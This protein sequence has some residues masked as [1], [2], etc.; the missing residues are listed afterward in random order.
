MRTTHPSLRPVFV[1]PSTLLLLGLWLAAPLA[2][3]STALQPRGYKA[4]ACGLDMNRNGVVGEPAGPDPLLEPG[5]CNV[6][7]GGP[8]HPTHPATGTPDPDGDGVD[9]DLIY[10]DTNNGS[11]IS[12]TGSALAPYQ[13]L[14]KAW[15]EAD[16]PGDGAEDIVCFRGTSN[17]IS[18]TPPTG[19]RG[20]ATTYTVPAAGSQARDWQY[21]SNP[22]M[23]VGWDRDNDG[24]YPPYDDGVQD[25]E[26]CGG[27]GGGAVLSGNTAS[28]IRA[29]HLAPDVG[30]LEIA[31]L[32][33]RDYGRL[34]GPTN[35]GFIKFSPDSEHQA[36]YLHD[37]EL[38]R[39]NGS[40]SS[41]SNIIA[42]DLFNTNLHWVAFENMLFEDNGGWF[43]RGTPH[44][45]ED[46]QSDA[47]PL[48]WQHITRI[49]LADDGGATNGFKPWG[50]ITGAEVLDSIFDMNLGAWSPLTGSGNA[51]IAFAIVQCN[52]DW[53]IRNNELIDYWGG[54]RINGSANG[55]CDNATA[56]PTTDIVIDR[57]ILRNTFTTW[58]F[59]H[60]A[61][62]ITGDDAGGQEGD[63][64]G[65]VVGTVTVSNNFLSSVAGSNQG[66][67]ESCIHA[68]PGNDAAPPPGS[69]RIVNN[70][71]SGPMRRDEG[72]GIL[73]G[74]TVDGAPQLQ[75]F[76]QQSF[77]VKNNIITNLRTNDHNVLLG[78]IPSNFQSDFNVYDSDGRYARWLG[79]NL[80][81]VG[82]LGAWR[83]VVPGDVSSTECYPLF[84]DGA[85]GNFHLRGDDGCAV[86]AG[87]A[88]PGIT[89]VDI[90]GQDRPLTGPWDAGADDHLQIFSDGF[91]S[92]DLD[93][94]SSATIP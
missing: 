23:L 8:N 35:S 59:G 13:T 78:Y 90:D 75:N 37:L 46:G 67:W 6:C 89:R 83:G 62:D 50:Y 66:Y 68:N 87:V 69:I 14:A 79:G 61:I 36:I 65:E 84:A 29:F 72:A 73:I 27:N 4:R 30:Y 71:C 58:D 56:R 24:C 41:D 33:V 5:D 3:V 28:A 51:T 81:G 22:A 48:R 77:V 52:Q 45:G 2:A 44:Q 57:N 26:H 9:E 17:E 76:M 42:I 92:G 10:V 34:V 39:I 86:G 43:A 85:S 11:D 15:A 53:V 47:G 32:K 63:A 60:F 93:A 20:L 74:S 91:E 19:Y 31:H 16:G 54:I 7:D 80:S 1:G 21:P 55:A 49:M 40:R 94:W 82:S 64:P 88:Q 38:L 12:G 70:T 18:L 25:P